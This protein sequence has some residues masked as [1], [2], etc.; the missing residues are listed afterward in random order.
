MKYPK[1]RAAYPP[2]GGIYDNDGQIY[3]NSET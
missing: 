3:A 2:F 1:K